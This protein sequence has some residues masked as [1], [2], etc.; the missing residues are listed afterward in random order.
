MK[1]V[2][3]IEKKYK[4]QFTMKDVIGM[5]TFSRTLKITNR[6]LKKRK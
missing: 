4:I 3:Q 5:E 2:A 6:Y 1:L